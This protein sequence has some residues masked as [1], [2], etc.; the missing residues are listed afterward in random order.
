MIWIWFDC[1]KLRYHSLPLQK[2][3]QRPHTSDQYYQQMDGDDDLPSGS[4]LLL[5][6]I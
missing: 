2:Y 1:N 4:D 3:Q 6:G 5:S